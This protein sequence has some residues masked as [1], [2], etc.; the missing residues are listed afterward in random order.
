MVTVN[1]KYLISCTF[2]LIKWSEK[3][4]YWEYRFLKNL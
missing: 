1:F 4:F 2:T 3:E